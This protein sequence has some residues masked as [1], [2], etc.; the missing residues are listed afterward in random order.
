MSDLEIRRFG[1]DDADDVRAVLELRNAAS[2][3]DAP[4]EPPLLPQAWD[5]RLRHG[6][7]G[8]PG[9]PYLMTAAGR[10]VGYGSVS[11]SERD[12]LH[13]AGLDVVVHPAHRRRGYGTVLLERMA[14]EARARGRTSILLDGW[15]SEATRGFAARNGLEKR[16]QD[17]NRRQHLSEVPPGLVAKLYDEAA[18]VATDYELVRI[19]GR[20]PPEMM[21]AVVELS[22]AI[23]DA[24]TDDLDI[25]D[26][27]MSAER[28]EAYEA[29]VAAHGE[30]LY[31]LVARHRGTGELGGH[32]VVAVEEA[33]PTFASQHDTAVARAHRGH[34]LGLLLK[35]GM[36]LWLAEVEP[37]V[38]TVDTWNAESNDH[39]IAVN[40]ALAYRIMGRGAQFQK[41]L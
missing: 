22:A 31:R 21:D 11:T 38:E 5:A 1:P 4:W 30:R 20:T 17:V 13:L 32:T 23:N 33:R 14:E 16:S 26:D 36:L 35:T 15:D 19:A 24:P 10:L 8:E 6:W 2:A 9:T 28:V 41:S 18:S 12:N 25:E 27:V 39:M 34:R 40:E 7:D 3:V 29:S 37:Q